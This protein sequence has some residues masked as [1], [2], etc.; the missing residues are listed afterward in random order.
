MRYALTPDGVRIA[1]ATAGRGSPLVRAPNA[2]FSHCQLE[3]PQGT[4]FERLCR[5]RMVV[6]FDPRGTGLSDRV[7]ED[8][9]LDARLL[10]IDAVA[11]AL[12]LNSF[13]L[14]GIGFS[15][16]LV[17][18]YAARNPARVSHLILDDTYGNTAASTSSPQVR[19]L[20]ELS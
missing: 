3:W 4:F 13:A 1:F 8:Y 2:P 16:P 15:G 6:P 14:H 18:A 10:D 17:I 11:D 20:N 19:A 5:H 9:S 12:G 7:V